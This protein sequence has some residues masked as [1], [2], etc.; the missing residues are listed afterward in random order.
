M[1]IRD[2]ISTLNVYDNGSLEDVYLSALDTVGTLNIHDNNS[3][4]SLDCSSLES[5]TNFYLYGNA[6]LASMSM[7]NLSCVG[8]YTLENNDFSIE[9]RA[10]IMRQLTCQSEGS[11]LVFVPSDTQD[12]CDG[13]GTSVINLT[14]NGSGSDALDLSCLLEVTGNV[15][16]ENTES[17]L[18]YTSPSPR[19][20]G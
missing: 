7:D 13:G 14:I 17:C 11:L 18:L 2:S 6:D 16:I 15:V 8:D 12:F 10:N 19:D 3:L 20:R 5:A 4:G 9:D 1:C